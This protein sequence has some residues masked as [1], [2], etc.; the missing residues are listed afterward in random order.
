MPSEIRS[1][2]NLDNVSSIDWRAASPTKHSFNLSLAG[3]PSAQNENRW[4]ENSKIKDGKRIQS[5]RNK[6]ALESCR[7][8]IG[9]IQREIKAR[10]ILDEAA[11]EMNTL[12]QSILFLPGRIEYHP[13]IS[14]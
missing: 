9:K 13:F 1:T 6:K 12:I 3:M 4:Q 10:E 7:R 8:Q 11:I 14:S 2:D 5:P